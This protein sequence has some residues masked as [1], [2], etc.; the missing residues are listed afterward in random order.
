MF[1][2]TDPIHFSLAFQTHFVAPRGICCPS[3]LA[4]LTTINIIYCHHLHLWQ[5]CP[6]TDTEPG[7]CFLF[8]CVRPEYCICMMGR[9]DIYPQPEGLYEGS[10]YISLNILTQ[11]IIQILSIYKNYIS[12]IS[13]SVWAMLEELVFRIALAA[14]ITISSICPVYE[15]WMI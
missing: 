14:H 3:L 6:H 12:S 15:Y 1:L 7:G 10:V 8:L 4:Q 5:Y 13:L 2:K 9:T 11:V